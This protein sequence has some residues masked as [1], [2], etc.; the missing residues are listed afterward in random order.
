MRK[1]YLTLF[2]LLLSWFAVAQ[3]NQEIKVKSFVRKVNDIDARVVP[4]KKVDQ[5][6]QTCALIKVETTQK[7]FTFDAMGVYAVENQNSKHPSEIWVYLSPGVKRITIQHP[8]W[9]PCRSY[10]FPESID[11]ATTYIMR[12]ELPMNYIAVPTVTSQF[13]VVNVTPK[14]AMVWLDDQPLPVDG[15]VAQQLVDFGKHRIRVEASEYHTY[16]EDVDVYDPDNKVTRVIKLKEAY[17][18]LQIIGNDTLLAQSA[19]YIDN[20]NGKDA[21]NAKK[22]L[23]SGS[24]VVRVLHKKYKPVEKSVVIED[25][26]NHTFHVDFEKNYAHI[27]L[28]VDADADIYVN[29]EL[30]GKKEW[31]GEL[32]SGTY[33]FECRMNDYTSTMTKLAIIPAMDGEIIHLDA[34]IPLSGTLQVTTVPMLANLYVDGELVG[35]S[36]LQKLVQVGTHALRIEKEGCATVTKMITIEENKTLSISE[37]LDTGRTAFITSAIE[38][39]RVYVDDEYMGVAPLEIDLGFGKHVI[40]VK[41]GDYE[42]RKTIEVAE[43]S[44]DLEFTFEFSQDV[45]IKTSHKG[46]DVYVDGVKVGV[47]PVQTKLVYGSHEIRA[48]KDQKHGELTVMVE[49]SPV[50][51]E[52]KLKLQ[53]DPKPKAPKEPKPEKPKEP[54]PEKPKSEK[55]KEPKPEKQWDQVFFVTANAGIATMPKMS[56]G[57]TVGQVKQFGWFLSAMTNANFKGM[58]P[59]GECDANGYIEGGYMPLYSGNT[60]VNRVSVIVGGVMR[61]SDMVGARL[62]VGYGMRNLNWETTDGS[63]YRNAGYSVSGLDMSAGLQLHIGKVVVSLEGVTTNFKTIEGKIGLGMAL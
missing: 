40:L 15:G 57:F 37:K 48:E 56:F 19:I 38:G 12:M 16:T 21:V 52:F 45:L 39:D 51:L 6:G 49:K 22:K 29:G 7:G 42:E 17:G 53:E 31:S 24:H 10:P 60:A 43:S 36:P 9:L 3:D 26:A 55:I 50:P 47:S 58:S 2:C 8:N 44:K 41:H 13:L 61:F 46:D 28:V 18:F 25:G 63:Y 20:A 35:T 14:D 27:K 4:T 54:K 59:V 32:V 1:C 30:K 5:N 62:G 34:P 23:G 33:S 11:A